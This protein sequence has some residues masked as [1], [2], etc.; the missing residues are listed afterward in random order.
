MATTEHG[1]FISTEPCV[2][3]QITNSW[4]QPC[5]DLSPKLSTDLYLFAN[6]IAKDTKGSCYWSIS[7]CQLNQ[8]KVILPLGPPIPIYLPHQNEQ[9]VEN[10]AEKTRSWGIKT[11]IKLSSF[12]PLKEMHNSVLFTISFESF[13]GEIWLTPLEP[14]EKTQPL[15]KW[16]R[17]ICSFSRSFLPMF[18]KTINIYNIWIKILNFKPPILE[19]FKPTL[20]IHIKFE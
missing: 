14:C 5:M 16:F 3:T 1:A 2:T 17:N 12:L 7:P 20:C 19:S 8:W 4:S 18:K 9:A 6:R 11:H 15:G 13:T 10:M